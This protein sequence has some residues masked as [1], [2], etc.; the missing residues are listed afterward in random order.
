MQH[1]R[2]AYEKASLVTKVEASTLGLPGLSPR[3]AV[4]DWRTILHQAADLIENLGWC[5]G[6]L[7]HGP[8]YCAVG[9]IIAAC[10]RGEI[11]E[12]ECLGSF[13]LAKPNAQWLIM[14][15]ESYLNQPDL[16]SWNDRRA[17]SDTEV[18]SVL[19]AVA[20]TK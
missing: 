20:A 19:R 6:A 15:V 9:A 14:K 10:N 7:R 16:M 8:R 5:R 13:L 4:E 2:L 12:D 1:F 3:R 17:R 18:V 11:P